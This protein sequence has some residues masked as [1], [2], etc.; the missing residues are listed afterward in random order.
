MTDERRPTADTFSGMFQ[1]PGTRNYLIV[2]FAA[3]LVYF[4]LMAARGSESGGLI[5]LLIAVPGL[6]ARWVISPVAVLLL[7]TYLVI[8]PNFMGLI[9]LLD[10]YRGYSYGGQTGYRLPY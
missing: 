3:L 5:A 1:V 4:L 7:T 8:D 2:G 10:E 9:G 6:L